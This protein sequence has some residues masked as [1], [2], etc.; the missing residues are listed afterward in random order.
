LISSY[1]NDKITLIT[2]RDNSDIY[3]EYLFVIKHDSEV[4]WYFKQSENVD[5]IRHILENFRHQITSDIINNSHYDKYTNLE[6][7]KLLESDL[8]L[9]SLFKIFKLTSNCG[10]L[11]YEYAKYINELILSRFPTKSEY[12][13]CLSECLYNC[14]TC[15]NFSA[16]VCDY[17]LNL[18]AIFPSL[19]FSQSSR[20][21][22]PDVLEY[23]LNRD[24]DFTNEDIEII[25]FYI[26]NIYHIKPTKVNI[27]IDRMNQTIEK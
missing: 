22:E 15:Y 19:D 20:T 23:L 21:S 26:E 13:E 7:I 27:I 8:T 11:T 9:K 14:L 18:G 1:L 6:I 17:L 3:D 10:K 2:S 25:N 5:I 4:I 16:E 12:I 24:Y